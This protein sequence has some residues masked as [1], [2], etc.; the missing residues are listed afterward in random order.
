MPHHVLM[1]RDECTFPRTSTVI[2]LPKQ[3]QGDMTAKVTWVTYV[4]LLNC[5]LTIVRTYA[6]LAFMV[7]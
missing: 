1:Y 4:T 2:L 5:W 7:F 6:V 3:R